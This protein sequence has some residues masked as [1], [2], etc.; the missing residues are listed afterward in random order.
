MAIEIKRNLGWAAGGE[1]LTA[2]R[3]KGTSR[4]LEI[5][6]HWGCSYTGVYIFQN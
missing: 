2:K 3:Q 6:L 4:V 5:S 1:E